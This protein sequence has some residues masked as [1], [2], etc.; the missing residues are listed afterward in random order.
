MIFDLRN[1]DLGSKW[2]RNGA[3]MMQIG[4]EQAFLLYFSLFFQF[5]ESLITKY[6]CVM[7]LYLIYT[8]FSVTWV[9]YKCLEL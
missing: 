4:P 9:K 8:H 2:V 1:L 5:F 3:I 7:D 6:Q